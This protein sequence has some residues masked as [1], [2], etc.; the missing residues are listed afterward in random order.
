MRT[1]ILE[2]TPGVAVC[3]FVAAMLVGCGAPTPEQPVQPE[4]SSMP[5][6]PGTPVSRETATASAIEALSYHRPA[7]RARCYEPAVA[8]LGDRP[9]YRFMLDVT[10]DAA[11]API[12]WGITEDRETSPGAVTQCVIDHLPALYIPPPGQ[13]TRVELPLQLP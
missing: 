2:G 4:K 6:S 12:S 13:V 11:G 7:L 9:V 10:F 8:G 5:V 3:S 1:A